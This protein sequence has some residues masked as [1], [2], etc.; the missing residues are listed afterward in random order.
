M[1]TQYKKVPPPPELSPRGG[2][3]PTHL[4]L[5][6]IMKLNKINKKKAAKQAGPAPHVGST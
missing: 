6:L 1:Y 5:V 4:L 3:K 2:Y